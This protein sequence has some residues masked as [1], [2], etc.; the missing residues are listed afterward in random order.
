MH[1]FYF[2]VP[3]KNYRGVVIAHRP[4]FDLPP[5]CGVIADLHSD[6]GNSATPGIF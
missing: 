2:V 1:W 6:C 5:I 3:A 4:G